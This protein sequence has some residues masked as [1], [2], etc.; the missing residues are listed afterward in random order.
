MNIE[1]VASEGEHGVHAESVEV[2]AEKCNVIITML[3]A[4]AHVE[5]VLLGKNADKNEGV[6]KNAKPGTIIIDSSTINP[7]NCQELHKKAAEYGCSMLDA[8]VSGGVTGAAAGTLTLMIGGD[9]EKM[10]QVRAV[11]EA[12]GSNLIHCGA[13]GGGEVAKLCNNMLL[14]ISMIGTSEAMALGKKF[15]RYYNLFDGSQLN[16]YEYIL[17][18]YRHGRASSS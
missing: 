6:L 7:S 3:P 5:E 4:T 15:G 9:K 8:P 18:R 11:F 10:E 14:G 2:I 1:S 17:Y 12:M 16:N 13:P